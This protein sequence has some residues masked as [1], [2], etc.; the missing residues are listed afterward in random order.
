MRDKEV[1]LAVPFLTGPTESKQ[2]LALLSFSSTG[3][4]PFSKG[5]ATSVLTKFK[6][7]EEMEVCK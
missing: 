1:W 3:W 5:F 7:T 4:A 2:S 6:W